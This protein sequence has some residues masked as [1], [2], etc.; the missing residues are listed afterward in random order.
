ML[1]QMEAP[2]VD[3]L[4]GVIIDGRWHVLHQ[5][6]AGAMGVVYLAER[7]K[8]GRQVALKL[9]HEEYASS[10]DFVRRFER[11]A[12]AISRLQHIHC[13]S[14][15]DFGAHG[16]RPYIVT[17]LVRGR[18]LT[19]EIGQPSMTPVRAALLVRQMLL[20]L[21]HAHEHGI[22]HRDLKP[23]NL[24]VSGLEGVGDIV[25]ILDFGFAHINDM[26][27]Q[28]NAQLVPGTPSYMSPE[29]ARGIRTDQR[30]DLYSAGVILYELCVGQKP[31]VGSDPFAILEM[32]KRLEPVAPRV[33]APARGIS[34]AL[35]KVILQAL[36]KDRDQ[37]FPDAP[38]FQEALEAT[39][40]GRQAL[41]SNVKRTPRSLWHSLLR[42][43][44]SAAALVTLAI[45]VVAALWPRHA[46]PPATRPPTVAPLAAKPPPT[47]P[48]PAP[49]PT[50][51]TAAAPTAVAMAPRAPAEL[52]A[53]TTMSPDSPA[54]PEQMTLSGRY[55][56]AERTLLAAIKANPRDGNLHLQLGNL[57]FLQVWRKNA[58]R[59]WDTALGLNPEL[60]HD[61]T[62]QRHLCNALDP[63][64]SEDTER[65]LLVHFGAG[66]VGVMNACIR[67]ARDPDVLQAAVQ[68][69]E[70][71]AGPNKVDAGLVAQRQLAVARSCE[72]R[73]R[74]VQDL[75]R[76]RVRRALGTL[77]ALERQRAREPSGRNGCLGHAVQDALTQ[78]R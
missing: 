52:P 4:S 12:R 3:P 51:A 55:L 8:L 9:L 57:Y 23:D 14:I 32:H 43:G 67:H 42:Y 62:L 5:I 78:L 13:I 15:L 41:R 49:A 1:R 65:L 73:K 18:P 35:E 75:G 66:V 46:A 17:E 61:P 25:K 50:T 16:G 77:S 58:L 26:R 59:E 31:F 6:G 60:R 37:R 27:S 72:E 69:I 74:A 39:P 19:A 76:L 48:A 64:S 70:R 7:V 22:V 11:E 68:V 44:L 29:Q 33:A 28:S 30:T 36:A 56:D 40:E 45:V 38:A 2:A 10:D 53:P 34:E 20:G 21:R 54:S 24:M 47:A 71:A 63:R